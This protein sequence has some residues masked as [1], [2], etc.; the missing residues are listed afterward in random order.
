[1]KGFLIGL[2]IGWVLC[3]RYTHIMIATECERLGGFFVNDK[4][5]KCNEIIDH[6]ADTS[7]PPVILGTQRGSDEI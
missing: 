4:T 7:I 5:F 1:M 2:I 6:R 3:H